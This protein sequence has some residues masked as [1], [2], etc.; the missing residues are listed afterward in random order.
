MDRSSL[1]YR[2]C[3]LEVG[4]RRSSS[5]SPPCDARHRAHRAS[6]PAS[7]LRRCGVLIVVSGLPGTGKS[8]VAAGVAAG[9][10][11]VQLSI[12]EAEDAMLGAGLAAGWETGVAAYEVTRAFAEQNLALG[13]VVVVDAV[14]DSEPARQTWRGAAARAGSGLRFVVLTCSDRQEHR[15]RLEGRRRGLR[16]LPEPTWAHV[17]ALA[18]APWTDPH[19]AVDTVAPLDTVVEAV[20]GFSR[21]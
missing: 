5:T 19:L 17:E 16:H 8:A 9:L 20:L 15:R 7:V 21:G 2:R 4:A 13:R 10:G 12:D 3:H 14:N 6:R 1:W 18:Y 11:A